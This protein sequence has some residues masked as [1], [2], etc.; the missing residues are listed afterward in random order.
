[1]S[2]LEKLAEAVKMLNVKNGCPACD[3]RGWHM[4]K[5]FLPTQGMQLTEPRTCLACGGSGLPRSVAMLAESTRRRE[6]GR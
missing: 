6:A 5:R 3:G 4:R 1:M 2:D